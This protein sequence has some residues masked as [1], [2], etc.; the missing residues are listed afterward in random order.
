MT[1][2]LWLRHPIKTKLILFLATWH[3]C[4]CL[5]Q[6]QGLIMTHTR[7]HDVTVWAVTALSWGLCELGV[8]AAAGG[9][10]PGAVLWL[11]SVGTSTALSLVGAGTASCGH[12]EG[13][14]WIKLYCS[15]WCDVKN[16]SL[17]DEK[18]ERT[19][20]YA[21]HTRGPGGTWFW[22]LFLKWN[23]IVRMLWVDAGMF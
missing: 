6:S 10:L 22:N 18:G 20:L 17:K 1:A 8:T 9:L 21:M 7:G 23:S 14:E 3:G 4:A 2:R 19:V 16:G 5:P 11:A 15:R 12:P 13:S